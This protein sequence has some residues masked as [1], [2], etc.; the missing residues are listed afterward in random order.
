MYVFIFVAL[1]VLGDNTYTRQA[2]EEKQICLRKRV[3]ILKHMV[4]Q[5]GITVSMFMFVNAPTVQE[6][7]CIFKTKKNV[8]KTA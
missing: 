2:F 3:G 5:T 7:F 1:Y 8:N 6:L 4:R